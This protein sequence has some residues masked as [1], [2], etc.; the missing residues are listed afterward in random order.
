MKAVKAYT[1]VAEGSD[2]LLRCT[3]IRWFWSRGSHLRFRVC[4]LFPYVGKRGT[5]LRKTIKH[6]QMHMHPMVLR[7]A[8]KTPNPLAPRKA[9]LTLT[10]K[11][12]LGKVTSVNVVGNH[13]GVGIG[14]ANLRIG[15]PPA[16]RMPK[17]PGPILPKGRL[18]KLEA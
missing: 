15:I 18:I 3:C 13:T 4:R 11:P 16:T 2:G 8:V 6:L 10:L 5:N 1:P 12:R 9:T 17:H 7:A 14:N